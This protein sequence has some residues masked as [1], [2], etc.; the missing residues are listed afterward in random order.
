MLGGWRN[1]SPYHTNERRHMMP[2]AKKASIEFITEELDNSPKQ[3]REGFVKMLAPE[4]W[5]KVNCIETFYDGEVEVV[6]GV[7]YIPAENTHWV[8]RMRM[9]GYEV[10]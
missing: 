3:D 6:E 9:N 7:A 5:G 1:P 10:A 2:K 4:Q 8:N